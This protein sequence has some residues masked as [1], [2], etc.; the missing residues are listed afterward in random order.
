MRHGKTTKPKRNNPPTAVRR[1]SSSVAE[2][3]EQV[4]FLT[5]ELAEA[6]EQQTAISEILKIISSSPGDLQPVFQAMLENATRTCVAKFGI[7]YRYSNGFLHLGALVG[8]PPAL[9][10]FLHQ[11]G[12]HV[13]PPGRPLDRLLKTKK[14]IHTLDQAAES[15]QVQSPSARLAGA[16]SHIA[17]PMLKENELIGS[18]SIYRQEVRP[19]SD[20]QIEL[21][22]NFA[23]QAVIE[24][25][26][27]RL[28][29]E[30]RQRTDDLSESLE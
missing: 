8:A 19:F 9:A 18:I 21:V 20:K 30:L 25:E 1:R 16:R 10:D 4:T 17:V 28:L 27:T 22:S 3:Q 11:Q 13:P 29:N 12:P 26:N 6:R 24:I 7:L 15:E 14:P 23:H 5:R 2:Q